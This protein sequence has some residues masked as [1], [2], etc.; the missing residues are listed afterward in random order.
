MRTAR[1]RSRER[2]AVAVAVAV[3]VVATVAA[4]SAR[5]TAT[6]RPESGARRTV[7]G[8]YRGSGQ[9]VARAHAHSR[10]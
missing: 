10:T 1:Q 7:L 2:V 8:R 4:R 3:L 5:G 9:W 6:C